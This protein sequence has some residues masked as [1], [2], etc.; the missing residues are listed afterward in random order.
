MTLMELS[1]K[2][3]PLKEISSIKQVFT[4]QQATPPLTLKMGT[5]IL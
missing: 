4:T 5:I 3:F 1:A 2:L